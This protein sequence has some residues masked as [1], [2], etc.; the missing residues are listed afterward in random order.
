MNATAPSL[1]E[2][3]LSAVGA[4]MAQALF[5]KHTISARYH[6]T[7]ARQGSIRWNFAA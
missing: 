1:P 2:M 6:G 5:V 4:K 3:V 7:M